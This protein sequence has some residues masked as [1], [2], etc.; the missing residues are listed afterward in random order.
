[1]AQLANAEQTSTSTGTSRRFV[2]LTVLAGFT[3]SSACTGRPKNLE[4]LESLSVDELIKAVVSLEEAVDGLE[5]NSDPS[6]A[7]VKTATKSVRSALDHMIDI[8]LEK[9]KT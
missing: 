6:V 8:R 2:T 1:V 4:H 3:S 5:V 9:S 7:G